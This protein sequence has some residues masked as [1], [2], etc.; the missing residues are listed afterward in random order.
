MFRKMDFRILVPRWVILIQGAGFGVSEILGGV[1]RLFVALLRNLRRAQSRA[2]VRAVIWKP[3]GH[4]GPRKP[5]VLAAPWL[6]ANR[7]SFEFALSNTEVL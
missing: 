7:K 3:S 4:P 1:G 5:D 2:T 6:T